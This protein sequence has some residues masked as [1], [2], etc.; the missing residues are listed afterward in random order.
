MKLLGWLTKSEEVRPEH[1]REILR[2][3]IMKDFQF[4]VMNEEVFFDA[5][6]SA[7]SKKLKLKEPYLS[8]VLRLK[9]AMSSDESD[10]AA[11]VKKTKK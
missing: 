9:K 7:E 11:I 8:E 1:E 4:E 6:V 10:D 5:K 3:L 2:T